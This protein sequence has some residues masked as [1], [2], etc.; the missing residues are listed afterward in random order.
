MTGV[1]ALSKIIALVIAA[2]A[3]EMIHMALVDWDVA[4][5]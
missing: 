1:K 4:S 5:E 2:V 3:A